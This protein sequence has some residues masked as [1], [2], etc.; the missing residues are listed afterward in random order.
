MAVQALYH[1]LLD[2][3]T[4]AH[5]VKVAPHVVMRSNLDLILERLSPDTDESPPCGMTGWQASAVTGV[6]R[7]GA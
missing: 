3:T 5:R 7:L 1:Y 2:G 6:A 4:P